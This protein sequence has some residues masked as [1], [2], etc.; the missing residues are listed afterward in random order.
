[1]KRDGNRPLVV[2]NLGPE[3]GGRPAQSEAG[4]WGWHQSIGC[5]LKKRA[6]SSSF[7]KLIVY[8]SLP[9]V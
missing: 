2:T 1:L 8:W 3:W 9:A 7:F 4:G 6:H 5:G